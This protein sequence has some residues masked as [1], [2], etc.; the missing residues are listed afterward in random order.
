ML[1]VLFFFLLDVYVVDFFVMFLGYVRGCRS[2]SLFAGGSLFFVLC[3]LFLFLLDIFGVD[4]FYV[5]KL[6]V[7]L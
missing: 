2:A 6:R 1:F 3:Y 5:S 7:G 4:F